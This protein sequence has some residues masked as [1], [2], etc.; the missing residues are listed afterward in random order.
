[1][2]DGTLQ[3]SEV[4]DDWARRGRAEGMERGH[5]PTAIR[6]F[7][8]LGIGADSRYL[9][10]GCGNGYTV[11]WAAALDASVR[12]TGIDVSREMIERAREQSADVTNASFVCGSFPSP[13]LTNATFDA[14]FSMEVFY[15]FEDLQAGLRAVTD[16]LVPGGRFACVVDFYRENEA[17]HEWPEL[18][19][20]PLHL[21][22]EGEWREAFVAAGLEVV[23]QEH[24]RHELKAGDEES[25]KHT[26]G[27]LMTLGRRPE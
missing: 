25:W 1:M 8:R 7:E 23:D 27:S 12:A 17:S 2:T 10:I 22:S 26:H 9:D 5:G 4:F 24:L 19:N 21:L 14:V 20:L 16:L 11:R 15:Y 13:E 3:V 18:M 6:A